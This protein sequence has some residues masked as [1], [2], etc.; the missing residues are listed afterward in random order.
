MLWHR[1]ADNCSTVLSLVA[2]SQTT[3]TCQPAARRAEMHRPSRSTLRCNFVR[4]NFVFEAGSLKN[5]Q[6]LCQCQK[7]P[8]TKTAILR[9]GKTISGTPGK[10]VLCNL[11]RNP[12][13]NRA[14]RTSIS[15]LVFFTRMPAIMRLRVLRSTMS[16]DPRPSTY[17]GNYLKLRG[18][19]CA[20]NG[21]AALWFFSPLRHH[22]PSRC[23]V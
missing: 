8:W 2:H 10:S 14:L 15:G 18:V 7:H 3:S 9:P 23:L 21:L 13:A 16:T 5:L 11:N 19:L 4:Q 6:P 22:S 12:A 17:L 20:E 1:F